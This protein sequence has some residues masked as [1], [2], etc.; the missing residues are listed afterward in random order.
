MDALTVLIL[1][2]GVVYLAACVWWPFAAC[3]RCGGNGRR[4]RFGRWLWELGR[5][6]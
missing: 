1:G 4:V 5:D 6:D 2:A 3:Q